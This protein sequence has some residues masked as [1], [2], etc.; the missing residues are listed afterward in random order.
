MG[1]SQTPRG[2]GSRASYLAGVT[3]TT[4]AALLVVA[5]IV[6]AIPILWK[7]SERERPAARRFLQVLPKL[8]TFK[9]RLFR[10][11]EPVQGRFRLVNIGD[12][13][14]TIKEIKTSCSCMAT[15]AEG[16]TFPLVIGPQSNA[17]V[18]VTTTA[19]AARGVEQSYSAA[20]VAQVE[21]E[22]AQE[23]PIS[24]GF[25]VVDLFQ[26]RPDSL[27]IHEVEA[28]VTARSSFVL[29]TYRDTREIAMPEVRVRGSDRVRAQ[30]R[31]SPVRKNH[32]LQILP[33]YIVE[34]TIEPGPDEEVRAEIDVA[35]SGEPKVT[36]PVSC[37]FRQDIRFQPSVL[38]VAGQAGTRVTCEIYAES[39]T[40]A[41]KDFK[42]VS[43][44]AG[45]ETRVE[46]F[47]SRTNRVRV[48]LPVVEASMA[49]GR[50]DALV[51]SCADGSRTAQVPIR[52]LPEERP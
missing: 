48:S 14:V 17:A 4:L 15:V 28:N 25:Q 34:V 47:D 24:L 7:T 22:A 31:T 13:P 6:Y 50:A 18:T 5:G 32:D 19:L 26:A 9:D 46:R 20:V 36:V 33:R 43:K 40:D 42:V 52:Y 11:G 27:R 12:R 29:F 41:W 16:G 39:R 37:F 45:C 10:N 49:A 1:S 3:C 21:G 38:T 35:T 23:Y 8:V 30:V 44:P 2:V 51:F